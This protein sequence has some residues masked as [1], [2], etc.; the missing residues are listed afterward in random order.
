[1]P[2]KWTAPASFGGMRSSGRRQAARASGVRLSPAPAKTSRCVRKRVAWPTV[3][4]PAHESTPSASHAAVR[5]VEAGVLLRDRAILRRERLRI[6]AD[7][8]H[9]EGHVGLGMV[10]RAVIALAVVRHR[11]PAVACERSV[12]SASCAPEPELPL[13]DRLN[14]VI[15]G[16]TARRILSGDFQV[17]M[18]GT[19]LRSD[20]RGAPWRSS[21]RR[22][23]NERVQP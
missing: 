23:P 8:D 4:S 7:I 22:R 11:Q 21:A 13:V 18:K 5:I 3:C 20:E 19:S 1:M 9:H 14:S 15:Y 16:A 17:A 2:H 10:H 12:P 6:E